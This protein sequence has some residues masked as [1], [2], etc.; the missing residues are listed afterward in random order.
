MPWYLVDFG[1]L[2]TDRVLG[3]CQLLGLLLGLFFL[4]VLFV[5]GSGRGGRRRE[6][7]VSLPALVSELCLAYRRPQRRMLLSWGRNG[8]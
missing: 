7:R 8:Q 1:W 2:V 4:A 5:N 6:P 3:I